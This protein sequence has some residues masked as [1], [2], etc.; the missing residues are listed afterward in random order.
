MARTVIIV[1]LYKHVSS[2]V[3]KRHPIVVVLLPVCTKG[4]DYPGYSTA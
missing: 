4:V 3:C 2:I 1:A